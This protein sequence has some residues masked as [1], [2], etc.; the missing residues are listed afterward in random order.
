MYHAHW[1]L[2][3]SPFHGGLDLRYLYREPSYEEALARLQ[4]L[5]EDNRRLGILLGDSGVGKSLLLS[6]FA[7]WLKRQG[8]AVALV[9]MAG[10]DPHDLVWSLA[11]QLGVSHPLG[12]TAG[13]LWRRIVDAL[14]EQR[15][16]DRRT[17]LLV[18]DADETSPETHDYLLRVAQLDAG[19]RGGPTMILAAQPQ[20]IEKLGRRLLELAE[21]RIDLR[22]WALEDTERY[23]QTALSTAGR[24]E[25]VF[26]SDAISHLHDLAQG[27]PRRIKQLADFSLAAGAG[28]G[29]TRIERQTVDA[30]YDEI[31]IVAP[32]CAI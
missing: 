25:S 29:A 21:L 15:L 20:R 17:V 14:A 19:H 8:S 10:A 13:V 24:E 5:V 9:S 4:F 2:L 32:G 22:C 16:Q 18:D 3:E 11:E 6:A 7:K 23:L 1:G 28:M 31:G 30:V 26:A 27:I 12:N